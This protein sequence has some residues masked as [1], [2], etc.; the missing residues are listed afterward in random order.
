MPLPPAVHIE[1]LYPTVKDQVENIDSESVT[2]AQVSPKSNEYA[3]V[4][5][6]ASPTATI[7]L[8]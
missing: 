3:N 7:I 8:S 2:L 1:P 6:P 4:P 5:D